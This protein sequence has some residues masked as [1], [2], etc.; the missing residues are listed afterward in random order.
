MIE[1]SFYMLC[2]AFLAVVAC[3]TISIYHTLEEIKKDFSELEK[4]VDANL[5]V[6]K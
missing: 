2:G 5:N 3:T 1:K 4:V 6:S